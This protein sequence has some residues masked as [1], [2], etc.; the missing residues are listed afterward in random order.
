MFCFDVQHAII[1]KRSKKTQRKVSKMRRDIN[2]ITEADLYEALA[3]IGYT[4]CGQQREWRRH[5]FHLFIRKKRKQ[6]IAL[7]LHED[8]PSS[9]PPFHR[10]RHQSKALEAEL[11]KILDAYKKRRA[12][13]SQS[14]KP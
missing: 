3:I 7:S 2:K 10:A 4:Q 13:K 9:F 1:L 5:E 12:S 6:G 14:K 11:D 8:M